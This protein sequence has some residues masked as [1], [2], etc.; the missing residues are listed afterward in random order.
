M[1]IAPISRGPQASLLPC[2]HC[3]TKF[4]PRK[5]WQLYCSPR[6]RLAGF[7]GA[8]AFHETDD[9]PPQNRKII[10]VRPNVALGSGGICAPR[11]V[12]EG[13]LFAGRNWRE[14]VS[15]DGVASMVARIIR[16]VDDRRAPSPGS[17]YV[18]G[19]STNH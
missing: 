15:A 16:Q 7:R 9:A 6:C 12:I 1:P 8:D 4:A 10:D 11:D 2:T 18:P 3:G 19:N 14:T 5:P 17:L 13:E